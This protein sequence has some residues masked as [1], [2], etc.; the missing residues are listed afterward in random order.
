MIM[1]NPFVFGPGGNVH[2][3]LLAEDGGALL[4]EDATEGEWFVLEEGD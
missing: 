4:P 2:E 1:I 3:V